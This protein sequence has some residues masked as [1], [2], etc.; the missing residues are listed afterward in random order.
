MKPSLAPGSIAWLRAHELKLSYRARIKRGRATLAI[1][2]LVVG[3][4][5]VAVGLP[6]ALVLRRVLRR[7]A[8]GEY[9]AESDQRDDLFPCSRHVPHS[10]ACHAGAV[11]T[12]AWPV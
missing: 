4:L 10:L 5:M 12:A 2:A 9:G 8:G 6:L 1:V 7:A 11:W 3:A